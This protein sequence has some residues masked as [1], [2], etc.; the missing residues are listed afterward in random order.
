MIGNTGAFRG[1]SGHWC[2]QTEARPHKDRRDDD[3]IG[4]SMILIGDS[5]ESLLTAA[6]ISNVGGFVEKLLADVAKQKGVTF[7]IKEGGKKGNTALCPPLESGR[8]NTLD[9]PHASAGRSRA[10][11]GL[12]MGR[13]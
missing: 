4:E 7:R 5:F 9:P 13:G 11:L 10:D 6:S 8:H 1:V 2:S 3:I 12:G